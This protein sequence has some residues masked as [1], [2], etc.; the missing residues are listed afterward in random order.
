MFMS[1]CVHSVMVIYVQIVLNR[2][3]CHIFSQYNDMMIVLV[4]ELT[5][6]KIQETYLSSV[7]TQKH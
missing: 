6:Y 7:Y 1:S 3:C 5:R 4:L 2:S